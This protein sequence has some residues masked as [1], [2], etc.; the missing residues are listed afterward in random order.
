[1]KAEVN[2]TKLDTP[3]EVL[4]HILDAACLNRREGQIRQYYYHGLGPSTGI[5]AWP[6]IKKFGG[7]VAP[8]YKKV[9]PKFKN[10]NT[11][12]HCVN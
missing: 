8:E 11:N 2:K 1:M 10:A 4:A 12:Q 7:A 3:D 6:K 9:V 5:A